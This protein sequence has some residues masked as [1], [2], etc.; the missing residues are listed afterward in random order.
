M[1]LFVETGIAT[2]D[3]LGEVL[4][5]LLNSTR[6]RRLMSATYESTSDTVIVHTGEEWGTFRGCWKNGVVTT[7][8]VVTV[9]QNEPKI[10]WPLTATT[11]QDGDFLMRVNAD[12]RKRIAEL[13]G[14]LAN[15]NR[16]IEDGETGRWGVWA[17]WAMREN[18][19]DPGDPQIEGLLS[20]GPER[21]VYVVYKDGTRK[22]LKLPTG[23][24]V[25]VG[26]Q[27][28]RRR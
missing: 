25:V 7:I 9:P 11:Y 23:P 20:D 27:G 17:S 24:G 8:R 15:P 5:R 18:G 12:L 19:I 4:A 16:G 28:V 26:G 22:H 3:D 13:E 1:T 21:E 14:L 10:G 2:V 6:A